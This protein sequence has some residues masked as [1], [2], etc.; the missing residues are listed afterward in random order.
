MGLAAFAQMASWVAAGYGLY[1]VSTPVTE[2]AISTA[3]LSFQLCHHGRFAVVSVGVLSVGFVLGESVTGRVITGSVGAMPA[4]LC[5]VW[6]CCDV[7][8]VEK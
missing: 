6:P 4:L 5:C 7:L 8:C 1:C 3:V 2:C